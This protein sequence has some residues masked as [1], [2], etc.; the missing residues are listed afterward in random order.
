[1]QPSILCSNWEIQDK[2][3][4]IKMKYESLYTENNLISN[5]LFILYS[6][7]LIHKTYLK[8]KSLVF[9]CFENNGIHFVIDVVGTSIPKLFDLAELGHIRWV[10]LLCIQLKFA[11]SAHRQV[12]L[13]WISR[14]LRCTFLCTFFCW[15]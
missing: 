12:Y 3:W 4:M 8:K 15:L 10:I 11:A 13:C 5:K 9:N 6:E 7:I 1:V 2:T 14:V